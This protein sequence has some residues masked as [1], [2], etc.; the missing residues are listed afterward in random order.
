MVCQVAAIE[1][2]RVV[3]LPQCR[4][5]LV[6]NAAGHSDE[7][8]FR[9]ARELGE[10]DGVEPQPGQVLPEGRSAHLHR[11]GGT[12]AGLARDVAAVNDVGA[13]QRVVVL[14]EILQDAA[15]VIAPRELFVPDDI[16]ER[17]FGLGVEIE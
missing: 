15:K 4:N 12:Q 5:K 1:K 2:Q 9:P 16:A 6:H 8:V 10:I 17:K 7:F 14:F 13:G 3:L 11:R